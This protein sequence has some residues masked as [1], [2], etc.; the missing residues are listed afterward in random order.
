MLNV[1]LCRSY[2]SVSR[3]QCLGRGIGVLLR[4]SIATY[5]IAVA[6]R[7][8]QADQAAH[9]MSA[10]LKE[11]LRTAQKLSQSQTRLIE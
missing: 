6:I 5:Q 2:L 4:D 1:R 8:G 9:C 3:F 7:A 10:H 11:V